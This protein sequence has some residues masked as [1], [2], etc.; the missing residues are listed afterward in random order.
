[1]FVTLVNFIEERHICRLQ[2]LEAY[3]VSSF[4]GGNLIL[5]IDKGERSSFPDKRGPLPLDLEEG[6]K[7]NHGPPPLKSRRP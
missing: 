5:E 4:I 6:K 3:E 7:G 1:M 2:N